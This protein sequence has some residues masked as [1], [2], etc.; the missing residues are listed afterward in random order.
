MLGLIFTA[1]IGGSHSI[2][3]RRMHGGAGCAE[4]LH[5]AD[6][7]FCTGLLIELAGYLR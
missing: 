1:I 5:A 6:D 7:R 2:A 3:R 4:P